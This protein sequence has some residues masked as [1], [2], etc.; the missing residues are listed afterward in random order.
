MTNDNIIICACHSVEHQIVFRKE[1]DDTPEV[2]A[3]IH[4]NKLPFWKRLRYA[5]RY[6]FGYQC[7]YGAFDEFLFSE[8]HIEPLEEILKT[9][10]K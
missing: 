8:E 2:Y 4:L 10:R 7:Q 3:E 5:I 6:V 1:I 9:L